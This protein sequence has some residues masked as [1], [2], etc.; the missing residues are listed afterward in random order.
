M[1]GTGNVKHVQI[2]LLDDPIQMYK[3]EVLGPSCPLVRPLAA[4]HAT[5]FSG[6]FN[7]GLSYR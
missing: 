5:V 4:L 6:C 3:D 7:S 2:I 1:P